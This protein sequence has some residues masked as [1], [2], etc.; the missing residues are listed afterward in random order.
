[1]AAQDTARADDTGGASRFYDPRVRSVVFQTALILA[2]VFFLYVI[3]TN[4]QANLER[5]NIASGFGF[6]GT[7]AG[8]G[9]IQT[10]VDYSEAS[11]YGRALIVGILN[12][13]L[14]AFLGIIIA[15]VLGFL[16]G[17]ARLSSNWL[18]SRI[19]YVY[20]EIVR[21]VPLLLQLFFWYFAVLRSVPNPRQSLELPG[22]IFVNNRG[23]YLPRPVFEAGSMLVGVTLLAA[24]GLVVGVRIWAGRR[25]MATGQR[26]PVLRTALAILIGLPLLALLFTGVPIGI[27]LPA[28]KGFNFAGGLQIGPEFVALLLALGLYTAA[29]VAEIVRAGILAVSHG[30]TEA[31]YSLGL[32]PNHTLRLVVVPQA[33]R[34]IVPPLTNQ[35]LNLTKNS[36]LAVAIAYPDLVSVGGTILNQ[37]GQAIEIIGIWMLV[38]LSIS[39][40]TSAFMNWYNR[41]IALVER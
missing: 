29:F 32:R 15:T 3:V 21:N 25:Q 6:L 39:L 17:I 12:T 27:E 41:R 37:T 5:Q 10:L 19:A 2:I 33:M 22:S 8:F 30:Q 23:I 26:F 9:I 34:V 28:L 35:F 1:M 38:Y 40:L 11:S 4:T 13:L 36:S 20:I 18:I 31:A 7:T 24:I 16:I 14:V